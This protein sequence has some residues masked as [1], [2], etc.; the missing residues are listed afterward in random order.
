MAQPSLQYKLL[1]SAVA[2]TLLAL[3]L[4]ALALRTHLRGAQAGPDAWSEGHQVLS[5]TT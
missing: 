3:A 1:L 4:L 2:L 5:D